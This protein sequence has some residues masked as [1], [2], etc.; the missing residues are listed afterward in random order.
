MRLRFVDYTL[1]LLRLSQ[2][3]R[4]WHDLLAAL[5]GRQRERIARFAEQIACTLGR[6]AEAFE[7]I[8]RD[9][10]VTLGDGKISVVSGYSGGLKC[11]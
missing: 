10:G 9:T 7:R 5:D 2:V 11:N 8:E 6:A 1:K 3:M 4:T